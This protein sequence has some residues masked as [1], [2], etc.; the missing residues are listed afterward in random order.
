MTRTFCILSI[1]IAV[2][3]ASLR[4]SA[5]EQADSSLYL[6]NPNYALQTGLYDLYR[7]TEARVVMLGNSITFG[8]N[9]NELLGRTGVVNRGIIGDV[10]DGML[11]RIDYVVRLHPKLCFIMAGIN[12]LYAGVPVDSVTACYERLVHL[13]MTEHIIPVI[14]STLYVSPRWKRSAEKN[15]E[16]ARLNDRLRKF[17]ASRGID[18]IDLNASLSGLGALREEFTYDGVHLNAHG[19]AAWAPQVDSV[20]ARHGL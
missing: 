20:L 19:Y 5:Q 11:H 10:I 4:A 13:L 15:P 12:D 3:A 17:A 16:V 7:T 14:Q 8:A 1:S 6:R 18:Y 2:L 9:W